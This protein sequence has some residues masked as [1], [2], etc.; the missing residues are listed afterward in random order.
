VRDGRGAFTLS[1]DFEL[2]WGTLDLFGPDGFREACRIEREVV[3]DR[4]LRL[5]VEFD[6]QAT[7]CVLG[8]LFLGECHPVGGAKH[9]EIVPPRHAWAP[10]D[11]FAHD[12]CSDEQRAPEFYGR[13]LVERIRSCPVPQE[14]GC[15][16]FSHVIFGDPGCPEATAESEVAACVRLA[17]EM[18]VELKSFAFPRNRVGH[19]P[20][21]ARHG[22]RS[23]RGAG[24]TW[25][26]REET[27][28]PWGRLAHLWDVLRA[29]APPTVVPRQD[30]HGLWDIPGSM[31]Y[32]PMHGVRRFVPV[33]RRVRRAC[34]GLEEAARTGRVFHLW[35][36]PTNMAYGSEKMFAGLRAILDRVSQ[37]RREGRLVVATMADL[38]PGTA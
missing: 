21:L 6:V 11:W 31:I 18:G 15:H 34:K 28:G 13:S 30:A 23:Y 5:F 29:A 38:V 7:W 12:P 35:F 9:P 17:R 32:F 8:H 33:S 19:L 26:E 37:L 22:F 16:S 25:Y 24:E 36:H 10:P 1:L 20:V 4:L 27:P 14:I 3:V 2:I